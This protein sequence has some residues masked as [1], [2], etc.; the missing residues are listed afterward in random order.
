ML[1]MLRIRNPDAW[2]STSRRLLFLLHKYQAR[3]F[4]QMLRMFHEVK[5]FDLLQGEDVISMAQVV[6]A[7]DI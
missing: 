5:S 2:E 6:E 4:A 3:D 1:Q 7:Q